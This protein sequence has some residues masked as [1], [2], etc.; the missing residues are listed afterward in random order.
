MTLELI[1]DDDPRL[2]SKAETFNQ[3]QW[4]EL[5]E[6]VN[7]MFE[8]MFSFDGMGLAAPQVGIMK[9]LFVMWNSGSSTQYVC[10]N[11]RVIKIGK[12]TKV[13]N[14]G[15]LSYPGKTVLVERPTE[16][17]VTYQN[18]RGTKVTKK[19]TGIMARCFLHELDHLNGITFFD[20]GTLID[21]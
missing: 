1:P 10:I 16:I 17:R 13:K 4:P 11:P 19:L 2:H 18:L 6:T 9:R 20:V 8:L 15:C 21:A 5:Q 14:E 12:E 3:H 7:G